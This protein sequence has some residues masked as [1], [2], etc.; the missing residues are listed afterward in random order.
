MS[1]YKAFFD[2]FKDDAVE[3]HCFGFQSSFSIEDLYQAF[4]AR[5]IAELLV[6]VHNSPTYGN[7]KDAENDL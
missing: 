2:K 4:K 6:D 5:L 7:L 3:T 1:E